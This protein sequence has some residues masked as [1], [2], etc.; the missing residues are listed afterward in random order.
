M[1]DLTTANQTLDRK[2]APATSVFFRIIAPHNFYFR[3]Y[4]PV[5]SKKALVGA[6]GKTHKCMEYRGRA[7]L[8]R[9]V[10]APK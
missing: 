1:V 8:Q 9:R 4:A 3:P 7:A 5:K 6:H 10:S 2:A